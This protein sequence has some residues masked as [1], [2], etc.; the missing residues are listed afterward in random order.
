MAMDTTERA[1]MA[2]S[3]DVQHFT[4]YLHFSIFGL[5]L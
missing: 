1:I 3:R 4:K 2:K 5:N